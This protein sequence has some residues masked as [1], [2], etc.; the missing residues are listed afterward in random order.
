MWLII[1]MLAVVIPLIIWGF[2]AGRHE[3]KLGNALVST[4]GL[5][6]AT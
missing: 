3:K 2:V 5:W 1:Y 4:A 6:S